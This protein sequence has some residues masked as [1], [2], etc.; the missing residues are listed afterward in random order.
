MVQ[1]LYQWG[2]AGQNISAI[3]AQFYAENDPEKIDQDYFR[4][5]LRTITMSV[6][7]IDELIK[8]YADR[9]IDDLDPVSMALL[10]LGV[11]E[12][13]HRLDV[14]FKVVINEGVNLA[15][16]FGPTDS[17]KYINGVLDK[18]APVIREVEVKAMRDS[19][20]ST[21]AK[22]P[23]EKAVKIHERILKVTEKRSEKPAS[24]NLLTMKAVSERAAANKALAEK[25][26]KQRAEQKASAKK[27][28]AKKVATKKTASEKTVTE[29]VAA[30]K[31]TAKKTVAKKPA[32]KK[33]VT[34]KVAA[35]KPVTKKAVAKKPAAKK[36]V[37]EKVATEKPATKKPVAKKPAAKKAVT[38]KTVAK[39][40][41]AKKSA[42]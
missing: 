17:D 31:P 38:K 7:E 30:K 23:V 32:V 24:K 19:P 28:A 42:D 3:E 35:E 41:A 8:V 37:A 10:R 26:D 27:P 1:A 15:K 6:D 22:K 25:E 18:M 11:F 33:V 9:D 36:A 40:S 16:R 5:A 4:E 29:K 39:K 21:A 34:K 12:F 13:R 2:M 20:Y 14:P